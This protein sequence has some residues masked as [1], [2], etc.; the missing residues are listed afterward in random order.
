MTRP[1]IADVRWVSC[2]HGM[3][4]PQVADVRWVSCHHG[5]ARPQVADVRGVSCH[6]GRA[7][8]QVAVGDGLQIRG[9]AANIFNKQ[10]RLAD[11]GWSSSL[12]LTSPHCTN[13]LLTKCHKECRTWTDSLDKRPNLTK[14]DM[15]FGTW[16][17]RSS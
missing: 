14:M 3:A 9:V 4:R 11:K 15:R 13:K 8:T 16:K 2:H 17:V 5:M 1:E 10:S 6:H 12:G 7:R